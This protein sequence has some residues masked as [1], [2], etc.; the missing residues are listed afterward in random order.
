MS[1]I[2]PDG[3]RLNDAGDVAQL[4]RSAPRSTSSS[5]SKDGGKLNCPCLGST[6]RRANRARGAAAAADAGP[7]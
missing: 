6:R 5:V 1:R 3:A 2:H 4:R 7:A